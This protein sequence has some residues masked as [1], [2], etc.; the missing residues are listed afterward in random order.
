MHTLAWM[1]S[2]RKQQMSIKAVMVRPLALRLWV[3]GLRL[4]QTNLRFAV[5]NRR[6]EK[7]QNARIRLTIFC[8]AANLAS[9]SLLLRFS[10]FIFKE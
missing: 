6:R 3:C 4:T 8:G 10:L 2:C 9:P 5:T 1:M 7:N